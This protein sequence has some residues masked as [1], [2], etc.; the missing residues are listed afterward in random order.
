MAS[1]VCAGLRCAIGTT[2]PLLPSLET[3]LPFTAYATPS[4]NTVFT[5]IM[6]RDPLSFAV[7][8]HSLE[9][10]SRQMIGTTLFAGTST[11]AS[12]AALTTSPGLYRVCAFNGIALEGVFIAA[13]EV[14]GV[15]VGA[16]GVDAGM[17]TRL[18]E[19][20]SGLPLPTVTG[21]APPYTELPPA[22]PGGDAGASLLLLENIE[23]LCAVSAGFS[24]PWYT[25]E[26]DPALASP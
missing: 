5:S 14:F 4:N 24:P 26:D 23:L 2:T 16:E 25:L 7:P 12:T 21:F 19:L 1:R 18:E 9:S 11:A 13:L 15:V 8:Y 20:V 22:D 6:T 3:T 17:E 10:A